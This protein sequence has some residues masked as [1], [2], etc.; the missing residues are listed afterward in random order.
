MSDYEHDVELIAN[1]RVYKRNFRFSPQ[2]AEIVE[3]QIRRMLDIGV[4]EKSDSHEFNSP[5]FLVSKRTGDW[6]FVVDLR[7]L[8]SIIRPQPVQL[9]KI[10]ELLDG[11]ACHKCSIMSS[12]DMK[13]GF[14]QIPLTQK[15]RKYTTFSNSK[16]EKFQYR[17]CPFG[18]STSPSAMIY[19]LLTVFAGKL[20]KGM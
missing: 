15:S 11:I 19:D 3:D 17:V 14:W 10:P 16:G 20:G 7:Q 18:L 8:N 12:V 1:K 2:D 5:C 6:R 4:I 13:T 9:P